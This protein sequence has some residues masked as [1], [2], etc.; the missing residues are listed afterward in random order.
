MKNETVDKLAEFLMLDKSDPGFSNP[1]TSD[2]VSF[3]RSSKTIT[4]SKT[5]P[6][7]SK[8]VFM[9][10]MAAISDK[11]I[12]L[13]L[14][15]DTS[16]LE[17]DVIHPIE[18]LETSSKSVWLPRKFAETCEDIRHI[19]PYISVMNTKGEVLMYKRAGDEGRLNGKV[20]IG[21]GGHIDFSDHEDDME[22][23]DI[24]N[25]GM[26][27][28]LLEELDISMD[29]CLIRP[30]YF[31]QSS[32]TPVD[33]VHSCLAYSLTLLDSEFHPGDKGEWKT[34]MEVSEMENLENWTRIMV[35]ALIED[36][37]A[38]SKQ[39]KEAQDAKS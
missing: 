5:I 31:Y 10:A 15:A 14:A 24:I 28:E 17:V 13:V 39:I 30:M 19:I 20:S 32:E 26:K 18:I 6:A 7:P 29:D 8:I 38:A 16:S 4:Y 12:N 37:A 1:R 22:V 36:I 23:M 27:R 3:N 11:S 21:W 35:L 2:C 34:L 25:K 33:S 9:E